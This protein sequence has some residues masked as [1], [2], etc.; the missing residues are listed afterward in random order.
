[1]ERHIFLSITAGLKDIVFKTT[2]RLEPALFQLLLQVSSSGSK[3]GKKK[4][5]KGK[6][7]KVRD[8]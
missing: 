8:S 5:K 4:K 2:H 3:R 6:A 7:G 1:M